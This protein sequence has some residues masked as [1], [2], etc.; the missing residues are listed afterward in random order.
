MPV[1]ALLPIRLP[2]IFDR[3]IFGGKSH[4]FTST[5]WFVVTVIWYVGAGGVLL[6]VVFP[7]P[8]T[9]AY[10]QT[11]AWIYCADIVGTKITF[12]LWT[13]GSFVSM[14][15]GWHFLQCGGTLVVVSPVLEVLVSLWLWLEIGN[16]CEVGLR[17]WD[18]KYRE[19]FFKTEIT[20]FFMFCQE[21][22]FGELFSKIRLKL[23]REFLI[24]WEIQPKGELRFSRCGRNKLSRK[25]G[26]IH[27][28]LRERRLGLLKWSF[29]FM[30]GFSFLFAKTS[31]FRVLLTRRENATLGSIFTS[32]CCSCDAK[33]T[34]L[35][36]I[37]VET[38][39]SCC[40]HW[41]GKQKYQITNV[42][43]KSNATKWTKLI[44]YHNK[45][46]TV[47]TNGNCKLFLGKTQTWNTHTAKIMSYQVFVR[48]YSAK[49][50]RPSW[51]P[52]ERTAGVR[53]T[54]VT[55][56]SEP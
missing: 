5:C 13:V 33:N 8:G 29:T 22:P 4:S 43:V 18:C 11:I 27:I 39:V 26:H 3:Q 30:F 40:T 6:C 36:Y 56:A 23:A 45:F 37:F 48:S 53:R 2:E 7:V 15:G 9:V 51:L 25:I 14:K 28:S 19:F 46:K 21:K 32:L 34:H 1:Q 20:N 50:K 16:G 54:C 35:S 41:R 31:N 42:G 38:K 10:R 12:N 49:G 52:R 24:Y 55:T 17:R 47:L 44:K